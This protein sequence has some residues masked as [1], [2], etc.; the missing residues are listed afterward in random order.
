[1]DRIYKVVIKGYVSQK[2]GMDIP[3]NWDWTNLALRVND[4]L[5]VPTVIITELEEV[6]LEVADESNT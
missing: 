2:D 1:M 5:D 4:F 3:I 6:V